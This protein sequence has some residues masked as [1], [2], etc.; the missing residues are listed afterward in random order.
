[1]IGHANMYYTYEYIIQ[2]LKVSNIKIDILEHE[3]KNTF[4]FY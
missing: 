1:M 2:Y 4:D 3:Q